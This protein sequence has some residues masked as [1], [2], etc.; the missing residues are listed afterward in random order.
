[1]DSYINHRMNAALPSL[2]VR[3]F[4][5]SVTSDLDCFEIQGLAYDTVGVQYN[6]TLY[7]IDAN[8]IK[9]Q[10]GSNGLV[11]VNDTGIA[12]GVDA[13]NWNYNIGVWYIG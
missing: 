10:T 12:F 1:M 6:F 2:L 9:L 5:S 8:N 11:A 4:V 13:Q 7:C 3:F